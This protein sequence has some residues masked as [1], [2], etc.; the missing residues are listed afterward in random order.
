VREGLLEMEAAAQRFEREEGIL[1]DALKEP[2]IKYGTHMNELGLEELM[3]DSEDYSGYKPYGDLMMERAERHAVSSDV[4]S[5]DVKGA[6]IPKCIPGRL[7]TLVNSQ[8]NSGLATTM[9]VA[10]SISIVPQAST[11]DATGPSWSDDGKEVVQM[12]SFESAQSQAGGPIL[13][14]TNSNKVLEGRDTESFLLLKTLEGD[15]DNNCQ[16]SAEVLFV[17]LNLF[18]GVQLPLLQTLN[19]ARYVVSTLMGIQEYQCA[20]QFDLIV[21]GS[22]LQKMVCLCERKHIPTVMPGAK[23]KRSGLVTRTMPVVKVQISQ[24]KESLSKVLSSTVGASQ[25]ASIK[26]ENDN[27][28]HVKRQRMASLEKIRF[29]HGTSVASPKPQDKTL[30]ARVVNDSGKDPS[31]EK[32]VGR[33]KGCP[34]VLQTAKGGVLLLQDIIRELNIKAALNEVMCLFVHLILLLV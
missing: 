23:R 8:D 7:K 15:A 30:L 32:K 25:C 18:L 21:V 14:Q 1:E 10:H 34:R 2:S 29:E 11:E 26:V 27:S 20:S 16:C 24:S 31:A 4:S 33:K 3:F 13:E 17:I 12:Q 5:A 22:C 19:N 6:N 28:H 9:N